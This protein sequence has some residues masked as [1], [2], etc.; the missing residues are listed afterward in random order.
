[1][2]KGRREQGRELKTYKLKTPLL[3]LFSDAQRK[4]GRGGVKL[5]F[6]GHGEVRGGGE[7]GFDGDAFYGAARVFKDESFG[8][9]E[10]EP[11]DVPVRCLSTVL[12]EKAHQMAECDSRQ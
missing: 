8:L 10:P 12:K 5:F 4:G 11:Q 3:L 6:K 9:F 1:M 7:S 2:A